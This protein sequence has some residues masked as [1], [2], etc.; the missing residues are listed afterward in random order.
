LKIYDGLEELVGILGAKE[1][2]PRLMFTNEVNLPK[3]P[4]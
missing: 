2:V 3:K 1:V 4:K